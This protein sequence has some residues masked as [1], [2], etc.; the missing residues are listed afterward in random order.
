M[1]RPSEYPTHTSRLRNPSVM[2]H[3]K[4]CMRTIEASTVPV[5]MERMVSVPS[6]SHTHTYL[7]SLPDTSD[8]LAFTL[9]SC[10]ESSK[11]THASATSLNPFGFFLLYEPTNPGGLAGLGLASCTRGGV[12]TTSFGLFFLLVV[13]VPVPADGF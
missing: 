5:R 7:L 13:P 11:T 9:P 4:M 3:G 12:S 10:R 6:L 1:M 8:A 2:D